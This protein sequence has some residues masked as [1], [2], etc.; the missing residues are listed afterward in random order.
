MTLQ[1]QILVVRGGFLFYFFLLRLTGLTSAS[2]LS[3][4]FFQ[5]SNLSRPLSGQALYPLYYHHSD[6]R[7]GTLSYLKLSEFVLKVC[8]MQ[9]TLISEDLYS[10][11]KGCGK[12][13]KT[14]T[15][16]S[17]IF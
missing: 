12:P 16:I 6:A 10:N 14:S 4:H 15:K 2:A 13:Q 9:A 1:V 17:Y 7:Q 3:D 11:R 8:K 5:G